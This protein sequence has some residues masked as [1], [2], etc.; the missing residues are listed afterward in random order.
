MQSASAAPPFKGSFT[1]QG[2]WSPGSCE[3]FDIV[4]EWSIDNGKYILY[5]DKEGNVVRI[6]QHFIS[7]SKYYN[8]EN[9]DIYVLGI[10]GQVEVDFLSDFIGEEPGII[11]FTGPTHKVTLPGYGV[12]FQ[13]GGRTTVDLVT[14][15]V[16]F[17]AGP[18]D[19]FDENFAALCAA[20]GG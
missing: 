6:W 3:T 15:D 2:A 18:S 12:V 8:S 14:F 16:T 5:F 19:F 17:Q 4:I 7:E 13:Q 9:P 1:D 10:P 11:S 20:L